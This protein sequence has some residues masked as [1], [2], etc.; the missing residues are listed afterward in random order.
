M[1]VILERGQIFV[2]LENAVCL[3]Y[4]NSKREKLFILL[5]FDIDFVLIVQM[6]Q[7]S[8]LVKVVSLFDNLNNFTDKKGMK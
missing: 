4:Q 5:L 6:H 3:N 7:S 2:N 8:T 1:A